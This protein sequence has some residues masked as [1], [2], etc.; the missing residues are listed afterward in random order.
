MASISAGTTIQI[1]DTNTRNE[2]KTF[3][4]HLIWVFC[5]VVIP[6]GDGTIKIWDTN[7]GNE[8]RKLE[9]HTDRVNCLVVLPNEQL[10]SGSIDETIKIC[11]TY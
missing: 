3:K 5:L 1:W 2:I 8:I 6:N 4:E 7:T 10:A 9:G 11:K